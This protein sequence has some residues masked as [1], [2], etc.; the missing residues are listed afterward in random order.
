M[1]YAHSRDD[2]SKDRWHL[3][4]DHLQAT[5]A[6]AEKF[7]GEFGAAKWGKLAGLWHDLGKYAPDFQRRLERPKSAK[8]KHAIAGAIHA[9]QSLNGPGKLLAYPI[10]GHHAGLSDWQDTNHRGLEVQ[11]REGGERLSLALQAK[12]PD[13]ILQQPRPSELLPHGASLSFW[14]RMLY[15]CLVDADFLDTEKFLQPDKTTEREGYPEIATLLEQY[16]AFM[17]GKQKD[18]SDTT[19][20]RLRAEILEQC[21]NRSAAQPAIFTLTVPTGGGKTLAS[22]GFAL[23]HAVRYGK[24][25]VIYVIPYTS[26]IEQTADEFR[27]IFGDAVVEH[28]HN[29]EIDEDG[30]GYSRQQLASE[31]WD[32]PLIVTTS[33]QFFESLFANRSSRCRKLH[34]IVNSVVIMDEAQL[35]PPDFL[36]PICDALTELYRYYKVTPVLC[37]ATQPAFKPQKGFVGLPDTVEIIAEPAVLYDQMKRVDA[38]IPADLSTPTEWDDLAAELIKHET[39]LCI[40]NRRDDARVLWEKMPAGT[41]HLSGRMCGAHR[42]DR[43]AEIKERL[44]RG[45]P[46]RV[47]STQLIEAGVDVDFPVVYRAI[48]GLD[49]IAQAAGR[50]NREG[51]LPGRGMVV[52][53]IPPTDVPPGHLR[54][55]ADIARS[56]I[57]EGKD[58]LALAGYEPFFRELFWLKGDRL[59]RHNIMRDLAPGSHAHFSFRTAA[60]KFRIIADG[61]QSVIVRYGDGEKWIRM[62]EKDGP[63]RWL[64]R[65]MQRYIVTVPGYEFAKMINAGE[66]AELHGASGIYVQGFAGLYDQFLGLRRSEEM[67]AF[68]PDDL[69]V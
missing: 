5:A 46:T 1:P 42:S 8:V 22:L 68:K 17:A 11:L 45:E 51:K 10:A 14:I 30:E 63:Q 49:S 62:L 47:I 44:S 7:A 12:P 28:H 55:A 27:K 61:Y 54:M 23:N 67:Q 59:D 35:L 64:M 39:V 31:N 25:R 48:A 15:S 6:L 32:A 2:E 57:G 16:N 20:N 13:E 18:A 9:I 41:F 37:T 34:N 58:P 29:V 21:L 52:V 69:L 53:F 40:V 24:R 60:E 56:S 4:E 38:K 36:N 26:I 19:I 33:V 43:I 3:L 65:K 66:V 50:C